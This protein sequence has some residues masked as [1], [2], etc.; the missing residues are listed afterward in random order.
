VS[1]TETGARPPLS[2]GEAERFGGCLC[3][4]VRYR[5]A[6]PPLWVAHC[7][8]SICR[9]AQGAG[10]V[11][12]VGVAAD[13]FRLEAGADVLSRYRSSATATRSFCRVCG[14]PL[15][16]ES[17]HWPGEIHVTL[18]SLD[19]SVGLEPTAHAYWSSRADWADWG[20]ADLA[21]VEPG[22]H[23]S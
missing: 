14:S 21:K 23:G 5:I 20:G 12:W 11:T 6:L 3:G 9:R 15:F 2:A 22:E 19:S 1:A 16:F 10:F 4:A 17:G 13:G 18:A 8:C 7:H